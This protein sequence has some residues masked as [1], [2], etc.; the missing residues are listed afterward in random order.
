MGTLDGLGRR[1]H[2][3]DPV[4]GL[5][6]Q[7]GAGLVTHR[8]GNAQLEVELHGGLDVG[9]A[10]V[11]AVTDP[12][13]GLAGNAAALLDKGL[14]V[15]QQLAGMRVVR[16]GVDDGDFGIAGKLLQAGVRKGA[17]HDDVQHAGHDSRGIGQ[18]FATSQ[19]GI[20]R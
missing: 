7:F 11:V 10:H 16:Q 17:D 8:A 15:G 18:W 3:L 19:L 12:G 5:G 13:H 20:A 9:I 4:A 14:H 6:Q 1:I 2:D